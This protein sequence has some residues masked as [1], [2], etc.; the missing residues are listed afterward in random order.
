M[1]YPLSFA[2]L[3]DLSHR[4]DFPWDGIR[5]S[6]DISNLSIVPASHYPLLRA[7]SR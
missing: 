5:N 4:F 3:G 2:L 1:E 7:C 6:A